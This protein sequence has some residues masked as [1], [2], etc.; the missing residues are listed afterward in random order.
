MSAELSARVGSVSQAVGNSHH[1]SRALPAGEVGLGLPLP[2]ATSC[3]MPLSPLG[4]VLFQH[5]LGLAETAGSTI[6]SAGKAI[7]K[8]SRVKMEVSVHP[9]RK[10]QDLLWAHPR[11]LDMPWP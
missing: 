8:T 10:Q 3:K 1:C 6:S 11:D 2:L 5:K 9:Q 4:S 7:G